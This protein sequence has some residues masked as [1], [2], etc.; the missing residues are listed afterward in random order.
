M[1]AQTDLLAQI[2]DHAN[3]ANPYPLYAE[4]RKAATS[5]AG[6]ATS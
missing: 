6:T 3:R 4:L 2:L 5:S 1:S